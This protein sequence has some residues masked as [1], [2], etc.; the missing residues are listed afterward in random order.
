MFCL[1]VWLTVKDPNDADRV[2]DLLASM[3]AGVRRELGN[4]R[5]VVYRST[6]APGSF[7]LNEHWRSQADW[8]A[9]RRGPLCMEMYEPLILPLVTRT[10]H[11][12][13]LVE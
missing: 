8:E 11:R 12:C 2:G 6:T 10:P 9:H 5:F 3:V 4:E 1:N 13:E 7:L